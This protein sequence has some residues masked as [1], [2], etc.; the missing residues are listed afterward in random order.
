MGTPATTIQMGDR[1][2]AAVEERRSRTTGVKAR[3]GRRTLDWIVVSDRRDSRAVAQLC[4]AAESRK[5]RSTLAF[6]RL[7]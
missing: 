5:Y 1:N 3:C 2:R 4:T 6:V 7:V